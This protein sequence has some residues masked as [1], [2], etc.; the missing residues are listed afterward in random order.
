MYLKLALAVALTQAAFLAQVPPTGSIR[1]TV[2]TEDGQ[3]VAKATVYGLREPDMTH[4]FRTTTDDNGRFLLDQIPAGSIHL[5]AFKESDWYPDNF[6]AFFSTGTETSVEA[7]VDAGKATENVVIHTGPKAGKL[8]LEIVNMDGARVS[9]GVNLIFTRDGMRGDYR[10]GGGGYPILVPA[11]PF[12]LTVEAPGYQPWRS[13]LIKPESM[14]TTDIT[15][16][17]RHL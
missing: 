16:R 14:K 1:G 17:L 11:V 2:L 8:N 5:S 7:A 15:V 3:P 4:Q 10:R 12:S 9:E 6:F 13:G